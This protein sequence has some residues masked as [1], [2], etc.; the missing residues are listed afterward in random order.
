MTNLKRSLT[1]C[2]ATNPRI[3]QEACNNILS[4]VDVSDIFFFSARGRGK[5]SPRG[6]EGGGGDFSW[7]VPGGGLPGWWARGGEGRG[8]CLRGI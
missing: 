4:L 6:R 2:P 8:G 1:G 3:T 7:K 5:G